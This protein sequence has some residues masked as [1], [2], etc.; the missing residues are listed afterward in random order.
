MSPLV[1][2]ALE[3]AAAEVGVSEEPPG[4]NRGARVDSYVKSVGLDPA[5]RYAWCCC[6]TFWCFREGAKALGLENPCH[7]TG[8]V[9][10]HWHCT[11]GRKIL[12]SQAKL[13]ELPGTVFVME[14]GRGLGHTGFVESV[15]G[16]ALVTIEGNTNNGGSREGTGVFRRKRKLPEITRGFIDYSGME[17]PRVVT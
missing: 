12:T 5:G 3:I 8:G 7:R 9:L 2:K 11:K 16:T 10:T 13:E 4:S 1:A 17:A 14:F 6:F 15:D